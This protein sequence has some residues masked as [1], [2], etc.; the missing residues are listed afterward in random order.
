MCKMRL[1]LS[2]RSLVKGHLFTLG[3]DRVMQH[4]GREYYL[5]SL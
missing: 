4:V 1:V 3:T 2:I 5:I